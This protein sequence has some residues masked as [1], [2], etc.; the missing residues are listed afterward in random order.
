MAA[1]RDYD[2]LNDNSPD[3]IE[4]MAEQHLVQ[5]WPVS[6]SIGA[7]ARGF[8]ESGDGIYVTDHTGRRLIDGPA[9]MWCVN[10]GHRRQELAEVMYDQAMQLSYNTP[11]YTMNAPSWALADPQSAASPRLAVTRLFARVMR[12]VRKST[13]PRV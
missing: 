3:G 5:P 7:E 2:D 10:V 11:W 6:G 1:K 12:W 9:G 13:S 4:A 8:I